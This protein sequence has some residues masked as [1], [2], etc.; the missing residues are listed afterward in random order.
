MNL[1]ADIWHNRNKL[2]RSGIKQYKEK[3]EYKYIGNLN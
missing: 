3:V 1:I 2:E